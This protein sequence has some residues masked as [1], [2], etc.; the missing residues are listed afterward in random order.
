MSGTAAE[1]GLNPLERPRERIFLHGRAALS[2][3]ELVALVLGGGRSVQRALD[4]LDAAGGLGALATASVHELCEARGVGVASAAALA[5]AFE[6]G[7]RFVQLDLPYASPVRTPEDVSSYVRGRLCDAEAEQFLVIGLDARARVRQVRVVAIGSLAQVD[8]H[9]REVFR[10]LVRAGMHSAIVV[11]NH[12]SGD[13]T[14]S[15]ADLDLTARL[16]D[17]GRLIGVPLV[18]HLVVTRTRTVSVAQLG[19]LPQ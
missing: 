4:V 1:I 14:P 11:H 16:A 8:V 3:L 18:D 9:P 15:E 7:K 5:A 12:P 6:L 19:L 10:P 2:D 13:A 17:A